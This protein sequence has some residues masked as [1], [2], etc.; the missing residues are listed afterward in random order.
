MFPLNSE[1]VR[2]PGEDLSTTF[3]P[4]LEF[5]DFAGDHAPFSKW[6]PEVLD[7]S[8]FVPLTHAKDYVFYAAIAGVRSQPG[9][10]PLFAPRG[11][12]PNC[13]PH[14]SQQISSFVD[15]HDVSSGVGWLYL[16]EIEQAL[17]A[18]S[19]APTAF[20]PALQM[21]L[22]AMRSLEGTIGPRHA[23]LVFYFS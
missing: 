3:H 11:L 4:L 8:G 19:V 5:D 13:S 6:A 15:P 18:A 16:D 10:A 20:S 12:P 7:L 21:L 1:P 17:R 22:D 9:Q 23:R 14:T 2:R